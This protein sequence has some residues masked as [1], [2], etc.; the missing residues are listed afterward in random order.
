MEYN[1]NVNSPE[2]TFEI[3]KRL[4]KKLEKGQIVLLTGDLG[5]G[6]TVITKG[7]MDAIGYAN[8]VTS[9]TYT[10]MN[11]YE[12]DAITVYHYD[13]YRLSSGDDLYDIGFWDYAG[14]GLSI[15]EWAGNVFDG[16]IK[17]SV[18][19]EISRMDGE[20]LT[21]RKIKLVTPLGMEEIDFENIVH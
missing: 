18:R 8:D 19:I 10:L 4:G 6:K 11:I 1:F 15:V 12:T 9:P 2:E 14:E 7:I 17:N 3:G 21:K 5:A 13:A 16:D 20:S